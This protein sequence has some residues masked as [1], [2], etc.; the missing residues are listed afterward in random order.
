MNI[1][2]DEDEKIEFSEKLAGFKVSLQQYRAA[3]EMDN[4]S[5]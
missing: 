4:L 1:P 3:L 2:E 5:M